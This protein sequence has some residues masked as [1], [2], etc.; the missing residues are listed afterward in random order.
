M[1]ELLESAAMEAARLG[2]EQLE[3]RFRKLASG[4]VRQKAHHDFVTEADQ[5]S[6]DAEITEL[7]Q[8]V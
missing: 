3:A 5:A 7:S 2:G 8:E 1:S 4:A 6:E